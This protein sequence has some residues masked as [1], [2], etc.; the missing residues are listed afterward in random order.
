MSIA[1]VPTI[2][3]YSSC[4]CGID[5]VVKDGRIIGR[6]PWKER[7][8]NQ[9]AK[10]PKGKNAYEFLYSKDRLKMPLVKKNVAF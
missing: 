6:E 4:G 9:E 1:C 3:P 10:C 8:I 5:L 7:P 2:C